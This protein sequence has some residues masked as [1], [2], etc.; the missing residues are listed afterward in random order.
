MISRTK[1][2]LEANGT[3]FFVNSDKSIEGKFSCS[4]CLAPLIEGYIALCFSGISIK[5]PKCETVSTTPEPSPGEII[6]SR[7][8]M[9][10]ASEEYRL[11]SNIDFSKNVVIVQDEIIKR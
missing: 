11:S 6:P 1:A 9:N 4:G 10:L 5:C 8:I 7:G 3:V 2:D